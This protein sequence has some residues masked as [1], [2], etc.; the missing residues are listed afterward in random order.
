M[1]D[2]SL[3]QI[4]QI[5]RDEIKKSQVGNVKKII[6]PAGEKGEKGEV[7]GQGIQG[8][9]G[10]KG[11]K[12]DRGLKG[13][14]GPK[15]EDGKDG[16][17]GDDGVGIAR[18]EQGTDS[19][20]IMHLTDG[21]SYMVEMPLGEGGT[22]NEVHY[23]ALGGGGSGV[24]DLSGYVK[25]PSNNHGGKWLVYREPDGTNQGEWAPATTDL[26]ETNAMLMFRDINGRFA[27]TPEELAELDNQLKVNRFIWEKIQELD[28]KAGGV[29]IS[30]DPPD[31]PENGMFWFDNTEDVMQLFIWHKDSDA[32]VP[33]APPTTLEGRVT[34][35]EATQRAI[36]DQ[37]QQSLDDQAKIV[38]KVEE[39]A[40]TKG[41][42][43][44]Y[45]VKDTTISGVASRNGE[46]YV[47]SPNAADVTAIS[48]APFD[49]NGQTTKPCNPDDI[50]EFVEAVGGKNAG[51][52]T[53]YKVIS[54]DY[55]ALTVEY[56]SGTNNFEVDEA[57]EVYIYP[58][59][60]DL[61]TVEYVDAQD[62]LLQTAV[63]SNAI[64]LNKKVH[65]SGDN[66]LTAEWRIKQQNTNG[67]NNTLIVAKDGEL[68]LYH[69]KYPTSD[70]HAANMKYVD[71]EI[72]KI[73]IPEIPEATE[74]LQPVLWTF[75]GTSTDAEDLNDG[76]FTF[77]YEGD[78]GSDGFFK[79]YTATKD[80]S[81]QLIASPTTFQHN[82]Q[83]H[84][85]MSI[86]GSDGGN[87]I[88]MK[89][90]TFYFNA[91]SGSN[92]YHR[93][94][95]RFWRVATGC[96]TGTKYVLNI[97]GI[98]PTFSKPSDIGAFSLP[99]EPPSGDI[100]PEADA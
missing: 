55:N 15:G 84:L 14:K 86:Q 40:I 77:R 11:P 23:K 17:D 54:G 60:S 71:D 82:M 28:L 52:V 100:P 35:G 22:M 64:E 34:A 13:D 69:V 18:I 88:H 27:P 96:T 83:D 74:A 16:E 31:D 97:P 20:I 61:A 4:L 25:R 80:A 8:P 57:E 33:V 73:V 38:A 56:L 76:E 70:A 37:I 67:N 59:N 9:K 50:V 12:G 46:L 3:Y 91:G 99:D 41:A 87:N 65:K 62:A 45:V 68:N 72:G 42:V 36:I 51:D 85:L 6:G 95:A 48:F 5:V 21:S 98:L 7:G 89:S 92:K 2:L 79:I 94:E 32:W 19:E 30:T 78:Q 29:A 90:K 24:V 49:L 53:R 44:R 26:I 81:G 39:L 58:Q 66:V 93:F 63:S 1:S 47:S 75:M 43:A 10:D